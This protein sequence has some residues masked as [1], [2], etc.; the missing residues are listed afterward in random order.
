MEVIYSSIYSLCCHRKYTFNAL[1]PKSLP[2]FIAHSCETGKK[3]SIFQTVEFVFIKW[4]QVKY[5][6]RLKTLKWVYIL[7]G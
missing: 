7:E 6:I 5:I 4:R 2:G 1:C 3:C